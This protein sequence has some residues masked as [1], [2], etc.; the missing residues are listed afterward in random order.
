MK[1]KES[2][3]Q[4]SG[5]PAKS[6]KNLCKRPRAFASVLRGMLWPQAVRVPCQLW[7]DRHKLAI[8]FT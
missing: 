8:G 6:T 5:S 3:G 7:L 1:R 2:G 4:S